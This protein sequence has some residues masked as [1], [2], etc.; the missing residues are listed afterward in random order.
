MFDT[1]LLMNPL[2]ADQPLITARMIES[3]AAGKVVS[4][5][6][7]QDSGMCGLSALLTA[8]RAATIRQ[9]LSITADTR[10]LLMIT[11]GIAD[12]ASHSATRS[13]SITILDS[14]LCS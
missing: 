8:P 14:D 6:G 12:A 9:A 2:L 1:G 13:Q 7:V 4:L 11:E 10:I 3:I 5:S